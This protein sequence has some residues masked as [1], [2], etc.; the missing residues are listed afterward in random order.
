MH[1]QHTQYMSTTKQ[2]KH[3]TN[4]Q[5]PNKRYDP[6]KPKV[7]ER[8]L[9]KLLLKRR[10]PAVV[11]VQLMPKGLAFAPGHKEKA[12]FMVRARVGR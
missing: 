10:G 2:T 1:K 11:L 9:R 6:V 4:Y 12:P 5:P 8:L 7:Y 3:T